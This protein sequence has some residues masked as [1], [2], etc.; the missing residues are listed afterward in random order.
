MVFPFDSSRSFSLNLMAYN[1]ASRSR[2]V[3]A[4]FV[5]LYTRLIIYFHSK[6]LWDI[7]SLTIVSTHFSPFGTLWFMCWIFSFFI[8]CVLS[9]ISY[10]PY[11]CA[12]IFILPTIALINSKRNCF[13]NQNIYILFLKSMLGREGCHDNDITYNE[14]LIFLS[15]LF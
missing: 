13:F 14:V 4:L 1:F 10:F 2:L 3:C 15:V 9:S 12:I 6:E 8:P 11:I 7:L 5:C